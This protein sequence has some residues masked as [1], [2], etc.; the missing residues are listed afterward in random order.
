MVMVIAAEIV[1]GEYD[2]GENKTKAQH[3]MLE[4]EIADKRCAAERCYGGGRQ[5]R[6]R[7]GKGLCSVVGFWATDVVLQ[8][9][10]CG[11]GRR[12]FGRS[13]PVEDDGRSLGG[14]KIQM[15]FYHSDVI[16]L[17][18]TNGLN[19]NHSDATKQPLSL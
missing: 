10:R 1:E 16:F 3:R 11:I 8:R 12:G 13:I 2:R 5:G 4:I 15:C 18:Q 19:L 6:R 14:A 17:H 7:E 9:R